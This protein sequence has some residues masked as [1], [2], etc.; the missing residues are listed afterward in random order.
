VF[1]LFVRG[2]GLDPFSGLVCDL[3]LRVLG[4]FTHKRIDRKYLVSQSER[5]LLG[6]HLGTMVLYLT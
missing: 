2:L 1:S 6:G 4:V 3:L 5:A